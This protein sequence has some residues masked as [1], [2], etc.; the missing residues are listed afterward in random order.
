MYAGF[1]RR[2]AAV[3]ID[4]LLVGAVIAPLVMAVGEGETYA[5]AARSASGSTIEALVTW[6]YY[7]LIESSSKQ[8][9]LG[10]MVL[11][12]IV[13]NLEGRRIG[14][15]RATGRHFAKI[16]SALILGI[17]F[18]MVAFTERK[19]GLHDMIAG[20]LVIRGKATSPQS[21]RSDPGALP[22]PPPMNT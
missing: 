1:W 17:G 15:G 10:K 21:T 2:V 13:T 4:G 3:F 9:T 16:L 19:Q 12:I 18:L 20:T 11:G 7:A 8:A 6:L 5:E 22:P 14:L